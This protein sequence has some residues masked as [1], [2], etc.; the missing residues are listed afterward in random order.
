VDAATVVGIRQTE[1]KTED[2]GFYV[3]EQLLTLDDRLQ[4]TG[5]VRFDQSS[6]NADD[7]EL[8]IFPNANVS[9]RFPN[10]GGG[11]AD[12]LKVRAAFGQ[13]GNRPLFGQEFTKLRLTENVQGLPGFTIQGDVAA[14]DL[15]P[16][17]QTE[18]EGG[19]DLTMFQ[20]RA[21]FEATAYYQKITDLILQ[22]TLA[23]SSG[24][25]TLFFNGG[26]LRNTGVELALDASIVQTGD[27]GWN[28]RVNFSTN[29]NEVTELPVTPFT[30]GS[31]GE[32]LGTFCVAEGSS[33]ND[34]VGTTTRDDLKGQ[35]D[36][37]KLGQATPDFNMNFSQDLRWKGL[38]LY[39]LWDWRPGFEVI[40]LTELLADLFGVSPDL[41]DADGTITP[42]HD[43]FPDCSGQER[44][45]GF[46]NG[47][48]RGYTQHA[49]FLKLREAS[50]SW[51]LPEEV[52]NSLWSGFESVRLTFS[53]RDLITVTDYRGLDP[54][55][56][57]FGRE[58]FARNV[59]VAPYPPSRSFWLSTEL[60][61]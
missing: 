2:F 55:V 42:V 24:F 54:E 10:L 8:Y 12:E 48:A 6:A 50:L 47:N 13:T 38:R 37:A 43:C 11:F 53:G 21:R 45:A 14:P 32:T 34:I 20:G 44:I 19:F 27:F 5:G 46:I 4:V 1:Q 61:F 56:S 25:N 29:S 30:Q 23:P 17:R 58:N 51:D 60:T 36:L 15:Q 39:H 9:L 41:E 57:N 26:E 59:D 28:Q 52:V 40:N 33:L 49:G 16:E 35:C 3:Q 31:F 18:I 22:R 7:E